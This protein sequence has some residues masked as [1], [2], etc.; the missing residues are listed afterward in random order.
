MK[1]S[2]QEH[3]VPG[4][5]FAGRLASLASWGYEGVE[6][7]GFDGRLLSRGDEIKAA[8]ADSP[9][10]ASTICGGHS[11][12]F[13]HRDQAN[14]EEAVRQLREVLT[15]AAAVGAIGCI[16]VPLFNRDPRVLSLE[17][18]AGTEQLQRDLLVSIMRPLAQ[19]AADLG[20]SILLEPLIR[21]ESNFPKNLA[22]AA[23]ICDEVD[24]PGLKLMADFFHMNVEEADIGAS[25]EAVAR[26]VRHIHLADSNRQVPGRGHTDFVS[27]F[28]ALRKIGYEGYGAL[29]CS[30]AE[31]RAQRL[32]ETARYLQDCLAQAA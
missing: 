26:Q 22:E 1:L 23:S 10:Q 31:P 2:C 17:P 3:L 25:L 9:V 20:V 28:R 14:R 6:L 24:S 5:T 30:V 7:T 18:F 4:D 13:I 16:V 32:Q 8:L 11:A 19:E 21:Y 15:L 29:E 12:Q 27:G